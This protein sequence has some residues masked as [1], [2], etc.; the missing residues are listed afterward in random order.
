LTAERY[1]KQDGA[2]RMQTKELR[3]KINIFSFLIVIVTVL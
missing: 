2:V 3:I 1:N